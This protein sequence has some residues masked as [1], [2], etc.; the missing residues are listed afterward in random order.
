LPAS[1]PPL[2]WPRRLTVG[3]VASALARLYT[4]PSPHGRPDLLSASPEA[5]LHQLGHLSPA[6]P[7]LRL[8][9][10]L[11]PSSSAA[12]V[13]LS[14]KFICLLHGTI[15]SSYE[16]GG[17]SVHRWCYAGNQAHKQELSLGLAHKQVVICS[18]DYLIS[19]DFCSRIIGISLVFNQ[20]VI[21]ISSQLM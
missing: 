10:S 19:V 1:P 15:E 16:V 2:G 9:S 11:S 3:P 17:R 5:E 14:L 13:V 21:W 12:S 20:I 18:C 7:P 4:S 8:S 6:P